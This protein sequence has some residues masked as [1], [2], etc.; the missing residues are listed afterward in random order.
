MIDFTYEHIS[1]EKAAVLRGL[2]ETV[3]QKLVA[4]MLKPNKNLSDRRAIERQSKLVQQLTL[5]LNYAGYAT[6]FNMNRSIHEALLEKGSPFVL[7]AY[8][9]SHK[10]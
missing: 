6:G 4:T 10:Y 2:F 9:L 3:S 7:E 8:L 5:K 1:E